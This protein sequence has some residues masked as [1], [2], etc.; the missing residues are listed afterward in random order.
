VL[1][2]QNRERPRGAA[3]IRASGGEK[4]AGGDLER[5]GPP[6]RPGRGDGVPDRLRGEVPQGRRKITDDVDVLVTSYDYP[7]QH[8]IHLSTTNPIESTFATVH[9]R[10]KV[11]KGPGP[12]RPAWR[13]RSS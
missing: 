2:S 12:T 4:G 11:T 10:T 13:W 3:E 8:W 5:R 7:D 9:H 6:V 1:L